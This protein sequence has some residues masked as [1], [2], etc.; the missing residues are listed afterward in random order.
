LFYTPETVDLV[1]L[2]KDRAICLALDAVS[3]YD[4]RESTKELGNKIVDI[5]IKNASEKMEVLIKKYL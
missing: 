1:T 4:P 3:G 5:F 2:P